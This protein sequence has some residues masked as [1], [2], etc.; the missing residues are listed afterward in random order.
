MGYRTLFDSR[1]AEGASENAEP[2]AERLSPL[3]VYPPP[4][5]IPL[6]DHSGDSP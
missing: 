6:L 3:S 4:A 1:G 2:Q 5:P